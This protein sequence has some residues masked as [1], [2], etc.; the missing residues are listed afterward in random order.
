MQTVGPGA[1]PLVS[2]P[3]IHIQ[4]FVDPLRAGG[5]APQAAANKR[6]ITIAFARWT[7]V[8]RV[9]RRALRQFLAQVRV[10]RGMLP[11]PAS[12]PASPGDD[13]TQRYVACLRSDRG[14]A[15]N[16]VLVYAPCVR[17]VLTH[18]VAKAGS[19]ALDA[20]DGETIRAFLIERIAHRSS[21]SARTVSRPCPPCC[22]PRT[23]SGCW[24]PPIGRPP[25]DV[26]TA[27]S[28]SYWPDSVCA[29][30]RSCRSSSTKTAGPVPPRVS[31]CG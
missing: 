4:S 20:L 26:A 17:D 3:E 30:A 29:R 25:G 8:E 15:D 12:R 5:Y 14:L 11:L 10:E 18:R 19:L 7:Q 2:P 6:A 28:C 27:R 22:R 9:E 21:E 13:L 16:S 23:S 24:P 31:F 1:A